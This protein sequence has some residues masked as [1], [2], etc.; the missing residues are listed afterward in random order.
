[1]T[2]HTVCT[3][4]QADRKAKTENTLMPKMFNSGHI[5][6]FLDVHVMML[7]LLNDWLRNDKG[8]TNNRAIKIT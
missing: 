3:A 1:M 5:I 2:M 8:R 4:K 6:S 7:N